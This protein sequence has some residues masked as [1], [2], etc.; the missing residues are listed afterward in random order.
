V[1]GHGAFVDYSYRE[2]AKNGLNLWHIEYTCK[3]AVLTV[4]Q[5][6]SLQKASNFLLSSWLSPF[7]TSF[8]PRPRP[9]FHHLQYWKAGRTW[10]LLSREDDI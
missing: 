4:N 10:Y 2:G 1:S 6:L 7:F 5:V 9:A 3:Q 8:I